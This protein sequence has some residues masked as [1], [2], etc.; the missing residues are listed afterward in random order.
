MK[1]YVLDANALVRFFRK[2]EGASTVIGLVEQSKLGRAHLSISVANLGEVY[3]ILAKYL[4]EEQAMRHIE[5][6]RAV[7]EVVPI[8]GQT[9]LRS[10]AIRYHYK[11]SF[12]DC[13]AA[14]LAMRKGAALV[15]ADPEF[16]R[17]GKR[18]KVLALPRHKS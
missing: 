3:Y 18:L 2:T 16:A 10:A 1:E 11:L 6:S 8:D 17:L 15:T 4:G 12:A 9:A 5:I 7:M 14:E 13:F